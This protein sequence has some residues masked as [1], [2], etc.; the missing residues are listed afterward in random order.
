LRQASSKDASR[1]YLF[2][3]ERTA[4]AIHPDYILAV[5][6]GMA[7]AK[8]P[9]RRVECLIRQYLPILEL[10]YVKEIATAEDHKQEGSAPESDSD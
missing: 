9:F 10:N 2:V 5:L 3:L 8:V 7:D 1:F 4:N 6:S